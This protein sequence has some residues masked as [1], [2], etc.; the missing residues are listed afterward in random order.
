MACNCGGKTIKTKKMTPKR[1]SPKR[2]EPKKPV[3]NQK[4]SDRLSKQATKVAKSAKN[5]FAKG[6][7]CT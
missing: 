4:M 7:N 3:V 2:V 5:P 1:P 6:C